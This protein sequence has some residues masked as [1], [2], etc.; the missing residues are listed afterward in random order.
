MLIAHEA[1]IC[2]LDEVKEVTDYQ[3]ALVHLFET[4][5]AYYSFFK[6]CLLEGKEVLL[7]NSIFELKEAF[8]VEKYVKYIKELQPTYF[9]VPDVLEDCIGT[10]SSYESFRNSYADLP[11]LWIGAIQGKTYEEIV[12]CYKYMDSFSD[13][14]AISFDFSFYQTIGI[15]SS[16]NPA[17]AKLERMCSGRVKLINMLI[18]DGIWNHNKPHHL[19]GNSLPQELTS[20]RNITSIRSVDTSNPVVAGIHNIRYIKNYGMRTKPD[21]L[22][23]NLINYEVTV[24]QKAD[25]FYNI[26]E[27]K[28]LCY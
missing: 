21:T 24:E 22:L 18:N 6:R 7:D 9:I 27:Y 13:Y 5:P 3:Y 12:E 11:G 25:I 8:N 14:I 19:L 2:L 28:K 17:R 1:P 16:L 15:S 20:Y 26:Q 23:A 10:I 4:Q